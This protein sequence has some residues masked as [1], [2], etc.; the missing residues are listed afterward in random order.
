MTSQPLVSPPLHH[1]LSLPSVLIMGC[2][3]SHPTAPSDLANPISAPPTS[4]SHSS[5]P[6]RPSPMA[7]SVLTANSVDRRSSALH[8][9]PH[10]SP[11]PA[12][13]GGKRGD[14]EER[15]ERGASVDSGSQRRPASISQ[16]Q[17]H[18]VNTIHPSTVTLIPPSPSPTSHPRSPPVAG[19]SSPS[20]SPDHHRSSARARAPTPLLTT[21]SPSPTP[22]PPGSRYQLTSSLLGKGHFAKV[23]LALDTHTGVEVAIKVIDKKEMCR[24]R[25][26]VESELSVLKRMG[27]HRHIVSLLDFYEDERKFYIVMELCQGGDLFGRIVEQGKYS[28][29]QAV[30]SCK[31]IAEAL[32]YIHSCGITHRDLKPENI[33]LLNSSPESDL[34]I[35]D[36]GQLSHHLP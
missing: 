1:R 9:Q 34:K 21:S 18:R 11:S 33:L 14:D 10:R 32:L 24:N 31:Q 6:K 2:T 26:I 29:T 25:G 19:R 28:E 23:A 5:P 17:P 7:S 22:A 20:T 30:R 4:S 15:K 36:F 27:R 16:Q 13:G 35:A 8:P 12:Q 3:P